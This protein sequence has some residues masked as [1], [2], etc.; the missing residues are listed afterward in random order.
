M[1]TNTD[2]IGYM[3]KITVSLEAGTSPDSMD[4]SRHPFSFQFIYGVGTEGVCLYEKA[5]FEKRTGEETLLWVDRHQTGEVFGHLKQSLI[6]FLPMAAPF[7][8][9]STV[10]AI[11]TADN[12]EIVRAIAKGTESSDC[13]CGC[14]GDCSC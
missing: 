5:L 2:V 13:G 3:K 6:T 9:K 10:T 12:R 14:G 11:E 7:Y 8:L 4:L 1:D